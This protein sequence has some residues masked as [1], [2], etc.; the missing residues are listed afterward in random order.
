MKRTYSLMQ[1]YIAYVL[2]ISLF[3]QSCGG[4]NQPITLLIEK[5]PTTSIETHAQATHIEPLIG[6]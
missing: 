3:L 5:E 4:L 2:F 1:Q 6:Q